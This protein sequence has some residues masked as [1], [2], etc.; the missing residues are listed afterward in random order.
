MNLMNFNLIEMALENDFSGELSED[1]LA[2]L[3]NELNLKFSET[4]GGVMCFFGNRI[5]NSGF[6]STRLEACVRFLN[7]HQFT[8]SPSL[9][10]EEDLK[11]FLASTCSATR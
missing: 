4:P 7:L 6:G 1:D 8:R 10:L 3:L 11:T 9:S 5:G 2:Y